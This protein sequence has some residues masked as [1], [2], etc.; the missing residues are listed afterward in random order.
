MRVFRTPLLSALITQKLG[1][2]WG[3][4]QCSHRFARLP[5]IAR[6]QPLRTVLGCV[7]LQHPEL[8]AASYTTNEDTHN[9]VDGVA[10]IWNIKYKKTTPEYI[11]NYQV[12]THRPKNKTACIPW[13]ATP[14]ITLSAHPQTPPAQPIFNLTIQNQNC[15][16]CSS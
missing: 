11:F 10:L 5:V 12:R 2:H 4:C 13:S 9:E 8:L 1:T 16:V 6:C 15:L 14:L 3:N 7:V